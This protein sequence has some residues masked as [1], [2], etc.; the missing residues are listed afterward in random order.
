MTGSSRVHEKTQRVWG[1]R[2]T[3][4][5]AIAL[6]ISSG[7]VAAPDLM[8]GSSRVH[9]KTQRV[10]GTRETPVRAI[11][12]SISSGPVAAPD[13]MTGSSRVHEKTQRVWGTRETPVPRDRAVDQQRPRSCAGPDDGL[14]AR[15]RENAESMGNAGDPRSARSRCRSAAAP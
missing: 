7:P 10:W 9:E 3:P 4:V 12:L 6:S 13:L 8:T 2:E 15:A 1:T 11:A 14:L 5:R